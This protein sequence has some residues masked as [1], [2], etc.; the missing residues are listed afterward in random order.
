[1]VTTTIAFLIA[2]PQAAHID[3]HE[4]RM[5]AISAVVDL[6]MRHGLAS[7][8]TSPQAEELDNRFASYT[9]SLTSSVPFTSFIS[10]T[11]VTYFVTSLTFLTSFTLLTSL[12]LLTSFTSP[13]PSGTGSCAAS[14]CA[15]TAD[16]GSNVDYLDSDITTRGA[17]LTQSELNSQ[18]GNSVV[19]ILT[20]V[21]IQPKD[22]LS[23]F[24]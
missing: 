18:G 23:G 2:P 24:V 11:S 4:V 15:D 22:F 3:T 20:K 6:L 16:S 10:I 19:A 21:R 13:L 12:T 5:A 7:F 9:S 1:M 17:T 14:R 8:I